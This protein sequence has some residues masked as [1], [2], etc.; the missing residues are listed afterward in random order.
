MSQVCQQ[1]PRL[2][3]AK[4]RDHLALDGDGQWPK[5]RNCDQRA[6][7]QA[8]ILLVAYL[9]LMHPWPV[10]RT[11]LCDLLWPGSTEQAALTNLRQALANLRECLAAVDFIASTRTQISLRTEPGAF[12]CDVHGFERLLAV[13]HEHA[14]ERLSHCP[15]CRHRLQEAVALYTAPL[16][17]TFPDIDSAP[18]LGWLAAHRE[19]LASELAEAQATLAAGQPK[20]GNLPLPLTPLVGRTVELAR[21][22]RN[23]QHTIYRCTS[24]VGPGGSARR[25]WLAPWPPACSLSF[26]TGS[27]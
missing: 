2:I 13:C 26:R 25:G 17:D 4:L 16:L 9:V 5:E 20:R 22:E 18:F 12:W 10:Q 21:L 27:G 23:L 11:T 6:A 15:L 14:H 19:R 1:R 7:A 24:L 3:R 8:G